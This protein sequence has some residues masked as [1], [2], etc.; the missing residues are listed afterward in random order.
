MAWWFREQGEKGGREKSPEA[1]Q[2][3]EKSI[4]LRSAA[5]TMADL[6]QTWPVLVDWC[7]FLNLKPRLSQ[8][9]EQR[10]SVGNMLLRAV[11]TCWQ[12]AVGAAGKMVLPVDGP[13]LLQVRW[14]LFGG[15]HLVW[16]DI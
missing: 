13:S 8:M 3:F 14:L 6:F 2:H 5:S 10:E 7:T 16:T 15:L 4:R 9:M 1:Q 11:E 12:G